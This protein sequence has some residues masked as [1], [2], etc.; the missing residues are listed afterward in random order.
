MTP[1]VAQEVVGLY[2]DYIVAIREIEKPVVAKVNGIALGGG[3][4]TA[5]AADIRIVSERA[6]FGLPF[7]KIGISGADMGATYL[8][9]RLVGYG[10]ATEMLMTGESVEAE[11]AQRI[12][13]VNR[14][15]PHEDL[16]AATEAIVRRLASNPT[17]SA[18][19][20]PGPRLE[21]AVRLRTLRAGGVPVNGRL[22]GGSARLLRK[23]R[24]GL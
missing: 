12:G 18:S 2:L 15:V 8:L 5:L 1:S 20:E 3:C 17:E 4:C 21:D 24:A 10:V 7:V 13:L 22:P 11:E 14:V 6:S 23:A 16:D 19:R 9:P